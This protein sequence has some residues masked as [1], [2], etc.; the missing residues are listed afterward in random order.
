[1][2]FITDSSFSGHEFTNIDTARAFQRTESA[3]FVTR[4]VVQ[5][6]RQTIRAPVP[7]VAQTQIYGLITGGQ[8]WQNQLGNNQTAA[9][10][11][12]HVDDTLD[13]EETLTVDWSES[14]IPY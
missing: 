13:L 14:G 10:P 9:N 11:I 2:N 8:Q 3:R 7:V 12:A 5:G 4:L 6:D 1:M